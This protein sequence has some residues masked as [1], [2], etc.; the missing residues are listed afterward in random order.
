MAKN[1]FKQFLSEEEELKLF[2]NL[3]KCFASMKSE[4]EVA[5]LLRDLLT[6]TESTTISRRLQIAELLLN[7]KTYA[8]VREETSASP[9][10]IAK[11]QTWLMN[12]GDGLRTAINRKPK[13][14]TAS[15]QTEEW[16]MLKKRFPM[17]FWPQ[18]LLEEIVKSAGI[19]NRQRILKIA[20]DLKKK[21]QLAPEFEKLLI[22]Q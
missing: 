8:K 7:G 3:A 4:E 6:Q 20:K 14:K 15:P 18:I 9:V 22:M 5:K 10:T 21:G 17:Y 11:I 2:V 16:R 12:Y 19:R 13:K 1:T